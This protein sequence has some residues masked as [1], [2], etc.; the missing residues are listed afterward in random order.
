MRLVNSGLPRKRRFLSELLADDRPFVSCADGS[1]QMFKRA[2]LQ[3]LAGLL[4]DEER[5]TLL[6]PILIEMAGEESE[7]MLLC[8]GDVER[9]VVASIL[10]MELNYERPGRIRLYRP[11]L[12]LLRKRLRTTTQYAFSARTGD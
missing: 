10:G 1:D 6:L 2:E 11:Q 3:Y 9:K 12:S 5:A 7:A 4:D 8:A